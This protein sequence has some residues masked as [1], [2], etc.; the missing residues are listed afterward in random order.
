MP[1]LR[2]SGDRRGRSP[3]GI[4]QGASRVVRAKW[5][6]IVSG[7]R[8]G[9]A[10]AAARLG[11]GA[12]ALPYAGGVRARRWLYSRG[13]FRT[14]RACVPVISVGNITA[15]GTGKT[16]VVEHLARGLASRGRAGGPRRRRR[17]LLLSTLWGDLSLGRARD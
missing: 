4:T 1:F 2:R 17:P 12:L 15:G 14:R 7:A 8:S 5:L 16:P 6:D 11:L 10:A 13:V 9:A 3:P